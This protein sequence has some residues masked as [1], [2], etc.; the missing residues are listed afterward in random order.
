MTSAALRQLASAMS[1]AHRAAVLAQMQP[2]APKVRRGMNKTEAAFAEHLEVMKRAGHLAW[3][4]FEAV[5][6]NLGGGAWYKCDFVALEENGALV[7]W[8]VKGTFW[9]EASR[10]R[11]KVAAGKF[12]HWTFIGV[13]RDGTGWKEERFEP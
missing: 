5:R 11:I 4:G 2:D 10:V 8:E 7:F 1:P 6:L 3:Y 13:Q 9:R 12:P